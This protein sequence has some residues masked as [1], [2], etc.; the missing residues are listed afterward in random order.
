MH[1]ITKINIYCA[2]LI[3]LFIIYKETPNLVTEKD[4]RTDDRQKSNYSL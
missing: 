1:N 2:C 4:C 3:L